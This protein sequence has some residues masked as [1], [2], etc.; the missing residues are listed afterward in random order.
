MQD[1]RLASLE[2]E[3]QVPPQ[4]RQLIG[5]RAE[6]TVVVETGL[7]DGDDAIVSRPG[8]ERGPT[9]IVDLRGVVRMD[10][11]GGIQPGE[12][13]DELERPL[14]RVD[15]PAGDEDALDAGQAR[16]AEDE[17]DVAIEPVG[18]DVAVAVDQARSTDSDSL[19]NRGKT[20]SAAITRP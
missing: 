9:G 12:P 14:A 5:D 1:R 20:G 15:V 6:H 3:R 8:D 18:I 13:I 11:D 10:T 7:A 17:L 19:S 2:R 16:S 4:V